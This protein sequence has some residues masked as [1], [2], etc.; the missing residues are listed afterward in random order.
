VAN[1]KASGVIHNIEIA[2]ETLGPARM[3]ELAA[4]LP[5][6]TRAILAR[7]LLP[8]EWIPIDDWMPFQQML[9]ER[10]FGGDEEQFRKLVRKICERDFNTFYKVLIKL[11][12]SPD[13]LIQRAAK[14]WSTYND[15]GELR[16]V[17]KEVRDGRI[18]V[19]LRV[20]RMPTR[21]PVYGAGIQAYVEQLLEMAGA[22]ELRVERQQR[23]S[24]AG[25]ECELTARYV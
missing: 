23:M 15:A 6:A 18:E 5:E 19:R 16:V 12:M 10:H 22:R 7:R 2:R 25:F 17:K 3:A 21:Y 20:E 9:L 24:A 11:V 4:T 13:A 8:V 1:I 14:L